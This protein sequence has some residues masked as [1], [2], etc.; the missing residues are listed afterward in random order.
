MNVKNIIFSVLVLTMMFSLTGC[1]IADITGKVIHGDRCAGGEE[2][3]KI[4]KGEKIDMCCF[5]SET[6]SREVESCNSYDM[7]YSEVTVTE[8][9]FIVQRKVV[10]PMEGMK[11][12]DVY[13]RTTREEKLHLITELSQCAK[14]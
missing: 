6:S 10:F 5:F 14:P 12:T 11:C 2:K 8:G 13:G 4:I 3:T 9:S 7:D 1:S